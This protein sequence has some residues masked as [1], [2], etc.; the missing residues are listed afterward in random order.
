MD[1]SFPFE[2]SEALFEAIVVPSELL[3]V[4][5]EKME[6]GG[7]EFVAVDDI[8]YGFEAHIVGSS[9]GGAAFDTSSGHPGCEG[10][11]IVVATFGGIA[12][13]GRLA[14]KFGSADDEGFVEHPAAFQVFEES[15][16]SGVENGTPVAVIAG[17]VFVAVPVGANLFGSGVLSS[18]VNLDKADS[19][20]HQSSG[21]QTLAAKGADVLVIEAVELLGDGRLSVEG[22]DFGGTELEPGGHF[23]GLDTGFQFGVAVAGLLVEL[24]ELFEEMQSLFVFFGGDS[25]KV[26][27]RK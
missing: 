13:S 14:A 7:M 26:L 27:G 21:Q 1:D 4:E 5:A 3:V 12:L 25:G 20:F 6:S 9:V 8:F 15:R 10:T 24:V 2:A 18:A 23:V 17:K 22:C 19:P 16:G 11:S